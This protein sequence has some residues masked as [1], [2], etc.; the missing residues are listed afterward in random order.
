[1]TFENLNLIK[2]LLDSIKREGYDEPTPIQLRSIPSILEGRDLFGCAQTGTGKTAA[3][4]LPLL[5]LIAADRT[6]IKQAGIKALVIAPTRELAIQINESFKTYGRFTGI[7]TT[8]IYGGISQYNQVKTIQRGIDVLI[9]TPG[10]LLD[11]INQHIIK[12]E[13]I[14]YFVLDEADKMLDMGF[15]GDIRQ[16]LA[17]LPKKRQTLFFAATSTP[18]I[19]KLA[20]SML[21]APVNV[22]VAPVTSTTEL[23]T[24]SVYYV[25]KE[26]K[27]FLLK[28]LMQH[29]SIQNA[30]VFTRTK[31]RA[32]KVA[33][34]LNNTGIKAESIH[35]DKSQNKR[36]NTLRGFKSGTI[37]VLVATDLASRGIDIDKLTHVINFEIPESPE[38]YIHRIGR[39]GRAGSKGIAMSFCSSDERPYLNNIN[40]LTKKQ[41][42]VVR[43]HPYS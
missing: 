3:F 14:R 35:G 4:A 40:K 39:T 9:A 32:D 16:I 24:E 38:V 37:Q 28:H 7:R 13:T 6:S 11:L 41:I 30:L 33:R 19:S 10:R 27:V 43:T 2:P 21:I 18:E 5:Q 25:R 22:T 31:H 1:M 29:Q 42:D 8:C 34:A 23:I 36:E 15:I 26:D 20:A 17:R 12:L